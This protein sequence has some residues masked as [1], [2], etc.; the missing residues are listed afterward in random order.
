[1]ASTITLGRS[2][3]YAQQFVRN[4][5]LTFSGTNDPA[6]FN[7]DWVR[8]FILS[9]PFSWR[10]NRGQIIID[11][12]Q[13]QQDYTIKIP[14]FGWLEKGSLIN[15]VAQPQSWQLTISTELTVESN[16]Q[17]P[18]HFSA[19]SDDGNGNITFR[20][21]P[22]PDQSY[23]AT[24]DFQAQSPTFQSTTDFWSPVPDYMSYLY[25]QGFLAKTYEYLGDTRFGEAATIFMRQLVA[26]SEG[27]SETQKNIFL[28]GKLETLRETLQAQQGRQGKQI[29]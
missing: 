7:A 12:V 9:P 4:A 21:F 19:Q 1:L 5:P 17:V 8:Q 3:N 28:N 22:V 11:L 23:I 6:F 14:T 24:I 25:N 20:F 15:A 26:C 27:L 16:Q 18:T 13:G 29:L 2:I 10:W